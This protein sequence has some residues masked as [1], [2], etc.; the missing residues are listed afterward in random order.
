MDSPSPL[1]T[2]TGY[3]SPSSHT[4]LFNSAR[5]GRETHFAVSQLGCGQATLQS[6]RIL[7][8]KQAC[9][10]DP[11]TLMAMHPLWAQLMQHLHRQ[12]HHSALFLTSPSPSS[13][14]FLDFPRSSEI[15]PMFCLGEGFTCGAFGAVLSQQL[16]VR[17]WI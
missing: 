10:T 1:A 7:V 3:T 12:H 2:L 13:P 17:V 9:I 15:A 14:V 8:W 4:L 5:H 6:C 16:W 11:C